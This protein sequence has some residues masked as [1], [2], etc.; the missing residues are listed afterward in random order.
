M[1]ICAVIVT[2][3]RPVLLERC[4]AAV[5]AQTVKPVTVLVVDNCSQISAKD[6]LRNYSDQIQ[7]FRFSVN[8]GGAGGFCFGLAETFRQGFDAAWVDR[9]L[10]A[11]PTSG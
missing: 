7:I 2:Y 10:A 8:S 9:K 1:R 6:V 11:A 3:N 4:V 5:L